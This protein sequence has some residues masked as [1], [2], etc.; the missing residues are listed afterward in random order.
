MISVR[1]SPCLVGATLVA[2]AVASCSRETRFVA[3]EPNADADVR[4]VVAVPSS[5][6]RSVVALTR[7]E[8]FTF[9]LEDVFV[10]DSDSLRVYVYAYSLAALADQFPGLAGRGAADVAAALSPALGPREA[11][12][13]AP[14]EPLRIS[15]ARFTADGS[16]DVVYEEISAASIADDPTL[17]LVFRLPADAACPP[18]QGVLRLFRRGDPGRICLMARSDA[19]AWEPVDGDCESLTTILGRDVSAG[20]R[21]REVPPR[22]L[23]IEPDDGEVVECTASTDVELGESRAWVCP[24]AAREDFVAI[25]DAV[26]D[27]SGEVWG[28]RL[29][30][31]SSAGADGVMTRAW[32][33]A[34]FARLDGAEVAMSRFEAEDALDVYPLSR[35]DG[36]TER[37]LTFASTLVGPL[38]RL[39]SN[40]VVQNADDQ[41]VLHGALGTV[42]VLG[43]HDAPA[44]KPLTFYREPIV[45][46]PATLP[47]ERL[48]GDVVSGPVAGIYA[49]VD[50]GIVVLR[51]DADSVIVTNET[52]AGL[53]TFTAT[54]APHVVA[55]RKGND[56]RAVVWLDDGTIR[57]FDGSGM[58]RV[59]CVLPEGDLLTVID[60]PR[61]VRRA[62]GERFVLELVD[63]GAIEDDG[64]SCAGDRYVTEYLVPATTEDAG[65]ALAVDANGGFVLGDR[66]LL[67]YHHGRW[68]GVLD[69]TSGASQA[70]E[71]PRDVSASALFERLDGTGLW[72]VAQSAGVAE[73]QSFDVPLPAR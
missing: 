62:A 50:T 32:R 49:V 70:I 13:Y 21:L 16:G 12:A 19:C 57:S 29:E 67:V 6:Q 30:N 1:S 47:R 51:A 44:S 34:L 9:P 15:T 64:G 11:G 73:L 38:R 33:G 52:P 22:T 24:G 48:R 25:Q 28:P 68:V 35:V 60:G 42:V 63:L 14:P 31:P 7:D 2:L 5:G 37:R 17:Q 23:A 53:V 72:G 65:G 54:S 66:E 59:D 8:P 26:R 71:L 61:L 18:G 20:T 41:V 36:L 39:T 45:I 58:P 3:R 43:N 4:V 10:N 27:A 56:E 40:R 55:V 46:S 69:L